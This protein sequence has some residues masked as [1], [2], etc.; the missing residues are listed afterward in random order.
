MSA[1]AFIRPEPTVPF[2]TQNRTSPLWKNPDDRG[3]RRGGGTAGRIVVP[4]LT[5]TRRDLVGLDKM[6][7]LVTTH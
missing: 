4:S 3:G 6:D 5:L 7:L 1:I 2:T